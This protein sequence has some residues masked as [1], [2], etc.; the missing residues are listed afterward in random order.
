MYVAPIPLKVKH[1]FLAVDSSRDECIQEYC[2]N[3]DT[4]EDITNHDFML[5]L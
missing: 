5:Y 3:N 1:T 4:Q 2:N